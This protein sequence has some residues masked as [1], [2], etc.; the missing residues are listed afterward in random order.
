M[1]NAST[2]SSNDICL[3]DLLYV[4]PILHIKLTFLKFVFNGNIS[5][6]YG[7]VFV[8]PKQTCF[9]RIVYMTLESGEIQD[10]D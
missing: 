5:K 8:N 10:L 6:N 9:Q 3:N 2:P 7:Q 4:C 1:F